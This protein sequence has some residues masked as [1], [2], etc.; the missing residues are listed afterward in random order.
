MSLDYAIASAVPLGF[1][2]YFLVGWLNGELDKYYVESWK[3][4]RFEYFYS[5]DINSG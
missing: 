2:N 1:M 3:S 4:K 5:D